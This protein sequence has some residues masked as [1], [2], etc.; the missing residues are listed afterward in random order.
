MRILHVTDCYLPRVGGIELHVRDL[1]RHQRLQ[2]NTVVVATRTRPAVADPEVTWLRRL[3]PRALE[4]AAPDVVHAHLSVVSPLALSGARVAA[5]LGVPTVVTVHSLWSDLARIAPLLRGSLRLHRLPIVW[6]AVSEPAARQVAAVVGR[7][8]EVVPNAVDVDFWRGAAAGSAYVGGGRPPTVLG[9][10]RLTT[11]KRALPLA[12]MLRAV[13]A[14]T[15]LDAV[16]VGDGPQR[17]ALQDHL[18]R[19]G[20][21]DKVRLTGALD[22]AAVRDAMATASVFVAPA[23]RESFGIAAL[24]ARAAGLPVVAPANSGVASLVRHGREGLLGRDDDELAGHLVELLTNHELGQRIARHNRS[25]TPP[26]TWAAAIAR[27]GDAY[28]LAGASGPL[29]LEAVGR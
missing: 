26:Q 14:R 8:V 12:R 13:A 2:G 27:N 28:E 10:M 9:V 19:H 4:A 7:P 3:D 11:V 16:I 23:Y 6:T 22:R 15:A 24:E 5:G 1:A 20:L 17:P 21:D 25:T 18:R 29:R